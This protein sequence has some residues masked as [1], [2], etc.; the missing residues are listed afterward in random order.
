[1]V[2]KVLK[3]ICIRYKILRGYKVNYIPGWDCHGLP[4]ELNALKNMKKAKK[5]ESLDKSENK[6]LE[7]R[8]IANEFANKYVQA[9]MASF[10]Q[11]NVIADW[12]QI[13]ET[14]DPNFLCNEIDLFYELYKQKLVYREYKPVY[15]SISS[16]TALAES[17][18][19]YN[20]NHKS[21]AMYVAFELKNYPDSIKSLLSEY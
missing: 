21:N 16:Q 19:E 1:M 15:W 6:S 8:R 9:Q 11:L 18:L 13:Y 12:N 20:E 10:K 3:D 2:N 17:E 5:T 14:K 4:I 7:T